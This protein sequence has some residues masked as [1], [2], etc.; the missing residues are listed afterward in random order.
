MSFKHDW[1]RI[2][3]HC[4]GPSTV[5]V[6]YSDPYINKKRILQNVYVN[7]VYFFV[8]FIQGCGSGSGLDPDP[9][10]IRIQ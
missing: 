7:I 8:C 9:D 4:D 3:V 5:T 2:T 6:Q 10:W 1:T